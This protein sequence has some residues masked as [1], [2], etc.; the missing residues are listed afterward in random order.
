MRHMC[1]STGCQSL[2]GSKHDWE[3][4]RGHMH[5][6]LNPFL[7]DHWKVIDWIGFLHIAFTDHVLSDHCSG[8]WRGQ[9]RLL[10][11]FVSVYVHKWSALAESQNPRPRWWCLTGN[12]LSQQYPVTRVVFIMACNWKKICVTFWPTPS[13]LSLFQSVFF[14][15]VTNEHELTHFPLL[16]MYASVY[17]QKNS[18]AKVPTFPSPYIS[19]LLSCSSPPPAHLHL[20]LIFTSTLGSK[21]F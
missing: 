9:G 16:D 6:S 3:V 5:C 7:H 8:R 14:C 12:W 18:L 17:R 15:S 11:P 10:K 19:T 21:D 1:V 13:S 4:F 2:S 20:M